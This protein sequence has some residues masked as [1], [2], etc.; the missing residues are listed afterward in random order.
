MFEFLLRAGLAPARLYFALI[1]LS[2]AS[3]LL[4]DSASGLEISGAWI[5]ETPPG[6]QVAAGYLTVRNASDREIRIVGVST[7]VAKRAHIHESKQ[8]DG[9]ATMRPVDGGLAVPPGG[10]VRLEPGG[11]HLM[12]V[13]LGESLRTGRSVALELELDD[14]STLSLDVPIRRAA[15]SDA[16]TH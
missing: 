6:L 3:A 8:V 1:V 7:P 2:F 9:Q 11:Y 13:G 14:G 16:H 4:A 15:E 5:R 12:L 10:V